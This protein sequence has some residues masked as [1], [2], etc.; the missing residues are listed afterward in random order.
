MLIDPNHSTLQNSKDGDE[1]R[2]LALIDSTPP[3][4]PRALRLDRMTHTHPGA[5]LDDHREFRRYSPKA[6]P[7][8]LAKKL[9][10]SYTHCLCSFLFFPLSV[11]LVSLPMASPL[12]VRIPSTKQA[13]RKVSSRPLVDFLAKRKKG[14]LVH[15]GGNLPRWVSEHITNYS[16]TVCQILQM[17]PFTIN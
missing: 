13:K 7:I 11:L 10:L 9:D 14:G 3:P 5:G 1:C 2:A 8:Y 6:L 4:V 15:L 17:N 12:P 16:A